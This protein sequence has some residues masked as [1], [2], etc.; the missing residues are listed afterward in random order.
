MHKKATGYVREED[1]GRE[2]KMSTRRRCL[3]EFVVVIK[4]VIIIMRVVV[5]MV[6]DGTNEQIEQMF[7]K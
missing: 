6:P 4:V 1:K 5:I 3:F 2:K 7:E